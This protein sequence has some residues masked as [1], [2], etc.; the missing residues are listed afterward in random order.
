MWLCGLALLGEPQAAPLPHTRAGLVA[1]LPQQSRNAFLSGTE[2]A[3]VTIQMQKK[4]ETQTR[5][6]FQLLPR[7]ALAHELL[8][9]PELPQNLGLL[10][11]PGKTHGSWALPNCSLSNF[12]RAGSETTGPRCL[13]SDT[14][15]KWVSFHTHHTHHGCT[16]PGDAT[17][18]IWHFVPKPSS[19]PSIFCTCPNFCIP[20][21]EFPC[22]GSIVTRALNV[23]LGMPAA[24]S[25]KRG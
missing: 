17:S 11:V 21:L 22:P 9:L 15:G 16:A 1:A 14:Q 3:A 7:S 24:V 19:L 12:G 13:F 23:T 8:V 2:M 4:A 5:L 10:E 25:D 20:V 6:F 18:R